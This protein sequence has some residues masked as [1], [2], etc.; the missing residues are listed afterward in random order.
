LFKTLTGFV[1]QVEGNILVVGGAG[2]GGLIL[3]EADI[4]VPTYEII[5]KDGS[6][7]PPPFVLPILV[8]DEAENLVPGK[9]YN[10][11]P[12]CECTYEKFLFS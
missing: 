1:V 8:F 3:N 12:T 5:F 6:T 4:N 2:T 11:Y 10:L 9:S 7:A